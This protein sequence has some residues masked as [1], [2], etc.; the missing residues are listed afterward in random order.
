MPEG[1]EVW[2]LSKMINE[3]YLNDNTISIGKHLIIKD[4]QEDWSF[5]LNGKVN[6]NENNEL[7][8]VETGWING[9]KKQYDNKSVKELGLDWMT[10]NKKEL[11]E[12]VQK[13]TNSKK[14]LAILILDQTK[15]CG[16][17]VAWGS[18]IL[19]NAKLNPN[20]KACDQLLDKLVDTMIEIRIKIQE[21]YINLYN[22]NIDND[23][24]KKLICNWFENLYKIRKMNVYKKGSKIQIS[25]RNWWI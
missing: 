17:G 9:E 20:L 4:I 10:A 14:K 8:K 5:G 25:G 11:E 15:I 21:T 6:I 18:E 13:W 1:P 19:Y 16:I 2:I 12:E 23:K 3:Y 24:N 22:E 7:V